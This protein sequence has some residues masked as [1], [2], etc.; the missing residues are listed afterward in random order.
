[1]GLLT[2]YP[3][4]EDGSAALLLTKKLKESLFFDIVYLYKEVAH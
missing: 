2:S 3:Y 1:M 4:K